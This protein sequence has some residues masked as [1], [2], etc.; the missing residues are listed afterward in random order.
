MTSELSLPPSDRELLAQI[1][2]DAISRRPDAGPLSIAW[3]LA[4]VTPQLPATISRAEIIAA[5]G[6]RSEMSG[7]AVDLDHP[8]VSP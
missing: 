6:E 7:M 3:L 8:T 4:E 2:D 1:L 5:I